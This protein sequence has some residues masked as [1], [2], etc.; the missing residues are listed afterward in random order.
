MLNATPIFGF[1]LFV[2]GMYF[3]LDLFQWVHSVI[4][5]L[6]YSDVF[7]FMEKSVLC[8]FFSHV[9]VFF[10]SLPYGPIKGKRKRIGQDKEGI[11]SVATVRVPSTII[12]QF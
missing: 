11:E 1:E 12:G 6:V 3:L 9:G 4:C 8:P 5:F 2:Y 10:F 7:V